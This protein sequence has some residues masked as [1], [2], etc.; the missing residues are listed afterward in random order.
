MVRVLLFT[1]LF[2]IAIPWYWRRFDGAEALI[3][4]V[5]RWFAASIAGSLLVSVVT[6]WAL[7]RPWPEWDAPSDESGHEGTEPNGDPT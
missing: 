6:A 4:G 1:A 2:A 5:P 3:L 7:R